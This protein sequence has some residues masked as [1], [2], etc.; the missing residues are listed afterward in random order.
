MLLK[1]GF[2]FRSP[3]LLIFDFLFRCFSRATSDPFDTPDEVVTCD[4]GDKVKVTFF[5]QNNYKMHALLYLVR[6]GLRHA[7]LTLL[8]SGKT[9]G[10]N[11]MSDAWVIRREGG[12]FEDAVS[13]LYYH[14]E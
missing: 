10:M 9:P 4:V 8:F 1:I 14:C 2:C 7:L 3:I 12:G 5:Q 13:S 6:H 11:F